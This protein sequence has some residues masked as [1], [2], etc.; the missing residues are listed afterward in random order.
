MR[1]KSNP[2]HGGAVIPTAENIV[3]WLRRNLPDQAGEI[4][5]LAQ[6]HYSH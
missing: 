4:L 3:L 1:I 5:A 6:Q 2:R